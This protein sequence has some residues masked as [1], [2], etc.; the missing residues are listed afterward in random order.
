MHVYLNGIDD[1]YHQY[2]DF[3]MKPLKQGWLNM[4]QERHVCHSLRA[5]FLNLVYNDGYQT[6]PDHIAEKWSLKSLIKVFIAY[7][8]LQT[9]VT[10]QMK[11][12]EA[13]TF[14]SQDLV[15]TMLEVDLRSSICREFYKEPLASE[16][17]ELIY[18]KLNEIKDKIIKHPNL[19]STDR[20]LLRTCSI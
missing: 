12:K 10:N 17:N 9:T 5:M 14:D 1:R 13:T 15:K 20:T 8:R 11:N 6:K 2:I 4:K 16:Y 19:S 3:G 18:M 7:A